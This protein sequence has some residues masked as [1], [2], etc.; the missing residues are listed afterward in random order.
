M[1]RLGLL[2]GDELLLCTDG[3]TGMLVEGAIPGLIAGLPVQEACQ[4]LIDAALAAGGKDNVTVV[5]ARYHFPM[6]E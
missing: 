1:T 2:D 5:L 6:A 4:T 3:L